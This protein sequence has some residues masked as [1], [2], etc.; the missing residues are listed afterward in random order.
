M[1][2][3]NLDNGIKPDVSGNEALRVAVY[4]ANWIVDKGYKLSN[5]PYTTNGDSMWFL[6]EKS[7]GVTSTELYIQFAKETDR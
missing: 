3:E 2:K 6:S 1:E 7:I 5:K 4:F